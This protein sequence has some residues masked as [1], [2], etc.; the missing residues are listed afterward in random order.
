M[1]SA[2]VL[3]ISPEK[4]AKSLDRG[5]RVQLLDIRAAERV[6]QG[7]VR[8]GPPLDFRALPAS[9]M[10]ALRD[11]EPLQLDPRQPVAVICGHGNSSNR[12]TLFRRANGFHAYPVP[13]CS[14][15]C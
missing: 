7:A 6:A 8:V 5:D 2:S 12:A 9:Q 13:R 15:A 10:Y 4:L 3:K 14:A 11:L 1:R